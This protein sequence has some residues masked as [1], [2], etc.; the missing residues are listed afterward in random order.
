MTDTLKLGDSSAGSL[1]K[2]QHMAFWDQL[3]P[4]ELDYPR[5]QHTHSA[6][7]SLATS[8]ACQESRSLSPKKGLP[9]P[10]ELKG[11]PDDLIMTHANSSMQV[12]IPFRAIKKACG[13][14]Y[15]LVTGPI[16]HLIIRGKWMTKAMPGSE[17]SQLPQLGDQ[18]PTWRKSLF[19]FGR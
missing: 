13:L 9:F 7:G 14:V 19:T 10:T 6:L 11:R 17:L 18:R 16:S 1:D 15:N 3:W 4:W 5:A 8:L 12:W 2:G